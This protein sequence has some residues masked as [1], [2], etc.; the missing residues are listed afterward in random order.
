MHNKKNTSKRTFIPQSIGNT[1]K[2]INR[3]FS[4]KFGKIEFII[5][6]K[7]PEITGSYFAEFSE[8]KS[9]TR[10]RNFENEIGESIFKNYLNVSVAPAA[11][12]E[13]LHFKDTILKKINSYFGYKA[14]LD[15]KIQQ[16]FV[17]TNTNST[18]QNFHEKKLSRSEEEFVS[19]QVKKLE[20]NDLKNSLIDLGTKISKEVK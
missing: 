3:N 16:N 9:I 1:L 2:K 17:N 12:V 10:V 20:N 5:K 18:Q 13:F 4:S 8:P 14:I 11:A 19:D 7:W 15:L 6:S